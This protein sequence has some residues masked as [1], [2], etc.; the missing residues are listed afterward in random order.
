MAGGGATRDPEEAR[1]IMRATQQL[2]HPPEELRLTLR[3]GSAS[4][5]QGEFPAMVLTLGEDEVVITRG[6]VH[7]FAQAEWTSE[8]LVIKQKVEGGGGVEDKIT[9][10]HEGH[11]VIEREIDTGRFKLD[12]VLR[13]RKGES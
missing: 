5:G 10:D 2:A 1:R 4:F 12:G 7:F 8:G 9:V 6:E 3:P 13:Y 11:L